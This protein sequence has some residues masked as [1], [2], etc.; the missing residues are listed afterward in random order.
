M[1]IVVAP[2]AGARIEIPVPHSRSHS[3]RSLPSRERGLKFDQIIRHCCH[4]LVAPLAGA[5]IE[6][7]SCGSRSAARRVAPLAGA[8]IEINKML[9]K[10]YV[11][12]SLPSRERGLKFVRNVLTGVVNSRSPRGSAD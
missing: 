5:R 4:L 6:I 3:L 2:L 10:G 8:R 1:D 12:M 11:F 7:P 9:G